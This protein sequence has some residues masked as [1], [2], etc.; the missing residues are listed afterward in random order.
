M[1]PDLHDAGR[2]RVCARFFGALSFLIALPVHAQTV[3]S[4]TPAFSPCE[5]VF[6]LSQADVAA[7]ANPYQSVELRAEFRSPRHRTFLLPAYWDGGQ[8]MVI[9]F[10]PT[11]PGNWDFR[12]TSNVES[13]NGKIGQFS[14][15]ESPS[16]GFVRV[17]NVHHFAYTS[18]D[19]NTPHL[20]M[21]DTLMRLALTDDTAFRQ[22]VDA[23]AGQKFTHIRGN[24]L[25]EGDDAVKA[26][27]TPDAPDPG[28]FR[29]LDERIRYINQKGIT[30]DLVLA[31]GANQL[32]KLFPDWEHRARY[33]RYLIARYAGMNITWGGVENFED[34][35][36][37]RDLVKEIGRLLKNEDPYQHLRSTGTRA[38]SASLLEDGWM[39]YVTHESAA[40]E[41]GAIEH[42]LYPA[43]FVNMAFAGKAAAAPEAFRHRLWNAAMDGDYVCAAGADDAGA[44]E[45]KI[46]FEFFADNRHWELE[47]Y[48]DVDGGRAT[49][50]EDVEY[51]LY[52]E[53]PAGPVEV[54]V[55]RH[56]YDVVW[57]NPANGET[58]PLKG[59][60]TE[61]FAGEPPDRSHD[62]VLHISREGHKQGMLKSYKFESRRILMQ[63][64]EVGK[65]PFQI[66]Q[67]AADTISLRSP[68]A[69]AV[70]LT[71]ETHATRSMMYLWTGEIADELQ[72][73]RV[74]GTG[75]KGAFQIPA[76]MAKHYPAVLH[77]R[78]FGMNANGKVYS[79]DRTYQLTQ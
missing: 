59:V 22:F 14:A 23:R 7:H 74:I 67:P 39:D 79:Q 71:R 6:E 33:I 78:L 58:V 65:V 77:V 25:G 2:I 1:G 44:V 66:V 29:Q 64:V 5:I 43:P 57:L 52:V 36:D 13:F 42:Q 18:G 4:S 63:E 61:R 8:R 55:E 45:M 37:G 28:Y 40:N 76:N 34:Y 47:P 49:A 17:A 12:V 69:Y 31:G 60:K 75:G 19:G 56:G 20:W 35:E 32:R 70:K 54:L 53:N 11:E 48:F 50:L 41:V 24:A 10:T 3:C 46:F 68:A 15:A 9:R 21:G 72:G 73:Y 16:P 27:P 62:W 38:T 30:V 51:I 26:F